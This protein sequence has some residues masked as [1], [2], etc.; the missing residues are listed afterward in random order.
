MLGSGDTL[1]FNAGALNRTKGSLKDISCRG[2]GDVGN[3][4]IGKALFV[5]ML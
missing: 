2:R 3:K 5:S 4:R 1:G